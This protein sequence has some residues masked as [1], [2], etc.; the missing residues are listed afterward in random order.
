[1]NPLY[2]DVFNQNKNVRTEEGK[3]KG[4]DMP[5]K[6]PLPLALESVMLKDLKTVSGQVLMKIL[7]NSQS[8]RQKKQSVMRESFLKEIR[9]WVLLARIT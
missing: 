1:M 3:T 6:N 9:L 5:T 4:Y 7:K 8:K 2:R